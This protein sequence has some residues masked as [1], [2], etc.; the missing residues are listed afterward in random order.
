MASCTFSVSGIDESK[1]YKIPRMSFS[2][3]VLVQ[4]KTSFRQLYLFDYLLCFNFLQWRCTEIVSLCIF[5]IDRFRDIEKAMVA[6][7]LVTFSMICID[8]SSGEQAEG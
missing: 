4:L 1:A 5:S 2:I 8:N 7:A 6:V 3:V